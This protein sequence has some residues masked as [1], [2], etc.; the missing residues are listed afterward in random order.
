MFVRDIAS[1]LAAMASNR[2]WRQQ[3]AEMATAACHCR[4]YGASSTAARMAECISGY[5]GGL[6][7]AVYLV[8]IDIERGE[9]PR[10]RSAGAL[11]DPPGRTTRES[12]QGRC[13]ERHGEQ[14]EPVVDPKT[15][16][17]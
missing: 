11:R 17:R 5:R 9:G 10:R 7:I 15:G 13:H 6:P 16:K 8:E 2:Y 3:D 1:A 12:D 4:S 14:D